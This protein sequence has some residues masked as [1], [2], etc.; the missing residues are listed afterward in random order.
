MKRHLTL[1]MVTAAFMVSAGPIMADS[2]D[3]V[4]LC[5]LKE[6]ATKEQA[7]T[8]NSTWLAWVNTNGGEGKVSSS[9]G[10]AIV[11]DNKAFLWIDSYPDLTSWTTVSNA[12]DSEAGK[13]ALKD[14]FKDIVD[15]KE[16]R[17]WKIE[18][19]K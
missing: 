8:A 2:V 19:T 10:T 9:V 15:C 4:G 16:N 3:E 12:T 17:L 11:G 5:T 6:G 18:S 7:Q 1:A 14:L 13:A